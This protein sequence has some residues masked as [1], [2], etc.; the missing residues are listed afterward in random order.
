MLGSWLCKLDKK[1]IGGI[2]RLDG[3]LFDSVEGKEHAFVLGGILLMGF[4]SVHQQ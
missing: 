4:A 3:S 1:V 2:E